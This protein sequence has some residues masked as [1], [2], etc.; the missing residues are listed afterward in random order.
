MDE[1]SFI[2]SI[3]QSSYRQP[4]VVKGIGDDAAVFRTSGKTLVTAVDT[5]V[6]GIHFATETMN[7]KQ[8][9][10]RALTANL[11]DLAAMGARPLYYLA[12]IVVP[13]W[14][15]LQDIEE[16]FN[17]MDELGI[18]Y[19]CDLI[20]GDT[21]QGKELTLSVTIIGEVSEESVRYR[22]DVQ[23]NDI[24]FTTGTLGNSA[25]GLDLLL[26]HTKTYD[27]TKDEITFFIERHRSPTPRLAFSHGLGDVKRMALNDISD[28]IASEL[29]ELATA[30][31]VDILIDYEKL[32]YTKTKT[33]I[34]ASKL[35]AAILSGGEDFELVGA[36]STDEW[37]LVEQHAKNLE[38]PLT[39]IGVARAKK[40]DMPFVILR[41][42][43]IETVL[44]ATGY[45][46]L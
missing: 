37:E 4:S 12:S 11:S 22:Q 14:C 9:G 1:F 23:E 20:G 13:S 46:H 3:Q 2:R 31:N 36:V 35:R 16:I 27:L 34:P 33:E 17:G 43:Q 41:E 30:S 7:F 28:G 24:I 6:E 42:K 32:P 15:S 38:I 21:V 39:K 45:N 8:V 25:I 44:S 26:G 19:D 5:F 10:Y 18:K 29:N 40:G